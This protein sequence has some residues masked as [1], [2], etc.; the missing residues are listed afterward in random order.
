[1]DG[2]ADTTTKGGAF[3]HPTTK[4]STITHPSAPHGHIQLR[5]DSATDLVFPRARCSPCK[6]DRE[7]QRLSGLIRTPDLTIPEASAG[8][9][10]SYMSMS[11]QLLLGTKNWN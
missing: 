6:W 2:G 11:G 10:W 1:M 3:F 9:T 5:Q 8:Q 4:P 7:T